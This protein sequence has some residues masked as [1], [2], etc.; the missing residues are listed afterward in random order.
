MVKIQT[1]YQRLYKA[2]GPQNWWPGE[3]PFEI[4]VG[5]ILTQNTAWTNVEKAIRNLKEQGLLSARGLRDVPLEDLAKAIRPAGYFNEKAKKLKAFIDFLFINYGGSVKRMF[6]KETQLLRQ[7]LLEIKG[8]GQE[9]ADSILL[10]AGNRAVF[11]VDAY[12]RRILSRLQLISE[13]ADYQ[14]IQQLFMQ[15]LPLDAQLFNE[16]HALFVRL[17]KDIC[18]KTKPDCGRCPLKKVSSRQSPGHQRNEN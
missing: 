13:K 9:T 2:F 16:F 4:I 11:V 3:G 1:I 18:K 5:A 7:E 12:T 14:K 17:G 8:I 10:Y 6:K 15:N